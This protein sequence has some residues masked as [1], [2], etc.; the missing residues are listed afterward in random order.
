MYDGLMRLPLLGWGL[1]AATV[2]FAGVI[3]LMNTKSANFVD[4]I[5]IATRLSTI[6]FTLLVAASVVLR[7]RPSGK[8][9]GLEPRIAALLGSFMMY[10]IL[11]FPRRDLSLTG[12]I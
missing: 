10:G 5:H 4:A 9:G 3:Q 11:L 6:A 7:T 1:F 2:Q 12:E 8:A